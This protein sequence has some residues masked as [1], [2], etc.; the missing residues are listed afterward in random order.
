M[1]MISFLRPVL[2]NIVLAKKASIARRQGLKPA[3]RP[4]AKTAI[5]DDIVRSSRTL[6]AAQLIAI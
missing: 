1:V 3:N 5:V 4:A 2:A 6:F